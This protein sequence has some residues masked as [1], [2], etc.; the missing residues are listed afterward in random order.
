M[1][2]DREGKNL[3]HRIVS[4]LTHLS[5]AST[6]KSGKKLKV[7]QELLS[8]VT[9]LAHYLKLLLRI[10]LQGAVRFDWE[11]FREDGLRTL[12]DAI[13]ATTQSADSS[14]ITSALAVTARL[15]KDQ[16]ELCLSCS[17]PLEESCIR[18]QTLRWHEKCFNC[19]VCNTNSGL[20]PDELRIRL[21]DNALACSTCMIYI[22]GAKVQSFER[23]TRLQQYVFLLYLALGRLYNHQN[24]VN[25]NGPRE[26]LSRHRSTIQSLNQGIPALEAS[27][28]VSQEQG[29]AR[30][31]VQS[32]NPIDLRD[33]SVSTTTLKDCIHKCKFR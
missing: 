24:I 15:A 2:F 9:G 7:T 1:S 30:S 25:H 13:R 29:G 6:L 17:Q 22:T 3:C 18:F 33:E 28:A 23:V 8:V 21:L 10:A 5:E 27:P 14:E 31:S 26:L 11:T 32:Q 16:S 19:Q 4:F 20:D 12:L